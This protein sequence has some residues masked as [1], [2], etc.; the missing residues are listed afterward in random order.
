MLTPGVE[1]NHARLF[2]TS[3]SIVESN[4]RDMKSPAAVY[5]AMRIQSTTTFPASRVKSLA[6]TGRMIAIAC[7]ATRTPSMK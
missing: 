3:L 2:H 5:G 4:T 6:A 7:V 1:A